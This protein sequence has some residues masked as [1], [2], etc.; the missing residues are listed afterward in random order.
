[1]IFPNKDQA[2]KWMNRDHYFQGEKLECKLSLDHDAYIIS[3]LQNVRSPKKLFVDNI[4]KNVI[5]DD[6]K[7]CFEQFGQIDEVVII[8]KDKRGSDLAYVNF[9]ETDD[10][11]RCANM[12]KLQYEDNVIFDIQ[13]AKP[14]FSKKMLMNVPSKMKT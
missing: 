12:K 2:F 11:M 4:P 13:L 1:M 3:S 9:C 6:L 8:Q 7:K 5:R 14:K 10:A